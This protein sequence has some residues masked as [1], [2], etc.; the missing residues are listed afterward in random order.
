LKIKTKDIDIILIHGQRS[1][2]LIYKKAKEAIVPSPKVGYLAFF[3]LLSA[4]IIVYMGVIQ[5]FGMFSS[6][7]IR[8]LLYKK[9]IF[10]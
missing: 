5:I 4:G 3:I 9:N 10:I 2:D 7:K 8:A 1:D 6:Y